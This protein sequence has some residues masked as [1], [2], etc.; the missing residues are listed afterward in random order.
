MN[1]NTLD[2]LIVMKYLAL[3]IPLFVLASCENHAFDGDKRQII[4][5]DEIRK[6]VPGNRSLTITGFQEDTLMSW[7][8]S[9]FKRPIRYI[10][11][12]KYNDSTG[13][14]KNKQGI[15]IFSQQG[16]AVIDQKII[17]H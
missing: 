7:H 15:I 2:K 9:T 11:D 8:D 4:A 10:L 3:L 12:F 1:I 14:E 5:K 6:I 13:A 17:D 16:N